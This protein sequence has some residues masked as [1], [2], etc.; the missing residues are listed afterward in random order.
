MV[1]TRPLSLSGF[2]S[3]MAEPPR[4]EE[5]EYEGKNTQQ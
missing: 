4:L 3:V 1:K 2:A 5:N